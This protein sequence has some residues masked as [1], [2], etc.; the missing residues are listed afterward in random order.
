MHQFAKDHPEE[1]MHMPTLVGSFTECQMYKGV[2]PNDIDAD[3]EKIHQHI[4]A[5][6]GGC[7]YCRKKLDLAKRQLA[8]ILE[9]ARIAAGQD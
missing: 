9:K 4:F 8:E 7:S 6:N 2:A 5:E 1:A 3:L